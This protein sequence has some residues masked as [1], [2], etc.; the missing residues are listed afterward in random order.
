TLGAGATQRAIH[1]SAPGTGLALDA[2]WV[3]ALGLTAGARV[4]LDDWFVRVGMRYETSL[5]LELQ[6][7]APQPASPLSARTHRFEA[8]IAPGVDL[9]A[10]ELALRLGYDLRV[11]SVVERGAIPAFTLHGPFE[12]LEVQLSHLDGLLHVSAAPELSAVVSVSKAFR[13][14]ANVDGYGLGYGGEAALRAALGSRFALALRYRQS[15][16]SLDA[17]HDDVERYLMLEGFLHCD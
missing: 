10:L 17:E 8:G 9:A 16:V 11:L 2:A 5:G 12:R 7:Q 15:H 3:P 13:R 14:A 1:A 6:D 4:P